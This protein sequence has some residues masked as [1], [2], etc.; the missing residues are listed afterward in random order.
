[1]INSITIF[2]FKDKSY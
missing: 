2:R 1:M